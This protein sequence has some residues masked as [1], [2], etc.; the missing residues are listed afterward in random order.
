MRVAL[1]AAFLIASS[2]ASGNAQQAL[3]GDWA[4]TLHD[5]LL[6]TVARLR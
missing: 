3:A 2:T 1:L 6:A 4:L 5:P